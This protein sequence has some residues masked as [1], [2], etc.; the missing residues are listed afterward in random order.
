MDEA[1]RAVRQCMLSVAGI[2]KPRLEELC[3]QAERSEGSGAVCKIANELFPKGF[4]CAGTEKAINALKGLTEKA[5]ALQAKILKTAGAFHTSLMSSAQDKLGKALD[6]TLPKMSS[7]TTQVYMNAT[8]EAVGP[9][10]D[11]KKICDLLK[12]QLVSS[13]LW[14]ASVRAMIKEG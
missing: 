14:E 6:E 8:A 1:A 13:V 4:S 10:T 3:K 11:P 2:D 9:D 7:P 12:K 5:G